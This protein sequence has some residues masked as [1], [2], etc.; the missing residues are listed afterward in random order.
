MDYSIDGSKSIKSQNQTKAGET[1]RRFHIYV[2]ILDLPTELLV[3]TLT[4]L[5]VA[6]LFSVRWTCHTLR[7]IIAGTAYLQYIINAHINGVEDSLP[8]DF[9]YSKR[10][11]LLRRHEQ[12]RNG[13]QFDLFT[14]SVT[15]MP[16]PNDFILQGGYLIYERP[17]VNPQQY[18]YTDLCSASQNEE[19]RW[20]HITMDLP[21]LYNVTFVTDHNLVVVPRFVS[22]PIPFWVQNLT[23]VIA[24][25]NLEKMIMHGYS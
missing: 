17:M 5:P 24:D 6:D 4:Y 2:S 21:R 3:M 25:S 11:E 14:E 8:P 13:L 20:V 10:L 22:F 16:Y 7:D 9:P 1:R 12:S 18:G 19:V 23:E 15:N